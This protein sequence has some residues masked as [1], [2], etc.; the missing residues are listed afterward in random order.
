MNGSGVCGDPFCQ[1]IEP[2]GNVVT[3]EADANE[4]DNR[5]R[6]DQEAVLDYV[7][8]VFVTYELT[9]RFHAQNPRQIVKCPG[10]LRWLPRCKTISAPRRG[11]GRPIVKARLRN[12]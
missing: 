12:G 9:D 6:G 4:D 5:D 11:S 7:L 10:C 3:E 1:R 2:G 8:T